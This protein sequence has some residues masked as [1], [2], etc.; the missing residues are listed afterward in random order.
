MPPNP[1]Y[2][3][4]DPY[5]AALREYCA[6]QPDAVED[7][8]WGQVVYKVRGKCFAMF[9]GA[10]PTVTLKP[11]AD[12]REAL[13]ALPFVEV[14]GYIGRYGWLTLTV[15]DEESLAL[16]RDLADVSYLQV[17][18]KGRRSRPAE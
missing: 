18:G 7:Y 1:D 17:R 5:C 15:T 12:E 13:L 3:S 6:D 11:D 8:P 2:V 14:A 9:G 16:A 4:Q 10:G